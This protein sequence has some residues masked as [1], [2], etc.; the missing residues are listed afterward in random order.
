[1]VV[2]SALILRTVPFLITI[3]FFNFP[4][5]GRNSS[6]RMARDPY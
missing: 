4:A 2:R 3:Y 6:R 1:M 5:G